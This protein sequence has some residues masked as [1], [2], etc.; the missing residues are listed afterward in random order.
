MKDAN[1]L[2]L[3]EGERVRW[4]GRPSRLTLIPAAVVLVV[5]VAIGIGLTAFAHP[6]FEARGWPTIL[7]LVPLLISLAG[8]FYGLLTFLRWWRLQYVIT[9]EEIYVKLGLI[10]R[11][12]TQV[13][14]TR[15]Q[16]TAFDQSVLERFLK[17]GDIYVYTAGTHTEDLH[18]RSVPHPE[19]VKRT[20]TQQLSD[21]RHIGGRGSL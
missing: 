1:W 8:L 3:T 11:D 6:R 16:N 21:V 5:L 4:S 10:S 14:L 9:D 7:A 2:H 20:L 13:P 18:L 17:Y 19:R 12:V 15:V